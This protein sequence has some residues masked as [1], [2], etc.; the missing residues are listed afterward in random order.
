MHLNVQWRSWGTEFRLFVCLEKQKSLSVPSYAVEVFKAS[1]H[2]WI[3]CLDISGTLTLWEKATMWEEDLIYFR[4]FVRKD[5]CAKI[6]LINLSVFVHDTWI[7]AINMSHQ[8]GT[9]RLIFSHEMPR[10][11]N[12]E[13]TKTKLGLLLKHLLQS[14]SLRDEV[15]Q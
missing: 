6:V 13:K 3:S 8:T 9:T 12:Q 1:N 5:G 15:K 2:E 14:H 11:I 10:Q 7:S 4:F